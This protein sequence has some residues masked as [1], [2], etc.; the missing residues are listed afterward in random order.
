ML[1]Q[2]RLDELFQG[3]DSRSPPGEPLES[4][5]SEDGVVHHHQGDESS[6]EPASPYP[7]GPVE[8]PDV[9]A[10]D[11]TSSIDLTEY[12]KLVAK[13]SGSY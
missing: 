9:Y 6:E 12:E 8:D 11:R 13:Q 4:S 10:V 5:Q 7:Q 2:D 1:E 3:S